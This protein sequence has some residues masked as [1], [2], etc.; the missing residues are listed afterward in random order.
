LFGSPLI[1]AEQKQAQFLGL[2]YG[3]DERVLDRLEL[4]EH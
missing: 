4:I 1:S 2:R 3:W